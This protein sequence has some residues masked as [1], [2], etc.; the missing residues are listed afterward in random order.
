MGSGLLAGGK[1]ISIMTCLTAVLWL[2]LAKFKVEGCV[3]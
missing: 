1:G 2:G 3:I